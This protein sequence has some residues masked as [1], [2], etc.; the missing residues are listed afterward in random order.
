MSKSTFIQEFIWELTL[1][2]GNKAEVLVRGA[3]NVIR[4]AVG[5][6]KPIACTGGPGAQAQEPEDGRQTCKI[7]SGHGAAAKRGGRR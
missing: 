5:I 7:C 4:A 2:D 3:I 1:E 6:V